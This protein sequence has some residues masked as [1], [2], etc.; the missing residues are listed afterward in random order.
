MKQQLKWTPIGVSLL[1]LLGMS[2]PAM[3]QDKSPIDLQLGGY[4]I[5]SV[6]L[7]DVDKEGTSSFED[8]GLAQ[9]GEIYFEAKTI[10][11]EGT[12]IGV[13]IELEAE[14]ASDDLIDEHYLYIKADWGKVILGAENGVGHLMQVRAPRFAPGLKMFDNSITE[15]II[16]E[17]YDLQFD[18]VNVI[19]DAHMSTKLEHISGDANKFSYLSP[20]VGGLQLAASFTPNNRD[21][22]GGENN[23]ATSERSQGNAIQEDIIELA[24]RYTGSYQGVGYRLSYSDVSSDAL[25]SAI[26]P[27]S[28]STGLQVTWSD[29]VFGA[30]LS[31]YDNLGELPEEQYLNS[32]SIETLNYALKYKRGDSYWGLGFTESEE[33][34]TNVAGNVTEYEEIMIGGGRKIAA[35]VEFGYY[36]QITEV[37]RPLAGDG[38]ETSAET[39]SLGLTLA[40]AF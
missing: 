37:D 31:K 19:Q 15:T 35:G 6:N 17:A 8:E 26:D 14:G 25:N 1:A 22:N 40:L 4:F 33:S 23:V 7:V 24:M 16:E 38:E 12:E 27:Q 9:S 20:K 2:S 28:T 5:Q 34:E 29:W 36:Y 39:A 10:L 32:E 13:R 18:A 11:P 30:N 3:A 21:R